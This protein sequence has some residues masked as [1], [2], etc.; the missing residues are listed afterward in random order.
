MQK[1]TPTNHLAGYMRIAIKDFG[2]I[3]AGEIT[4]KPL[5]ILVGPNGCGKTHVSTL[6][7]SVVESER[8]RID[9]TL[10]KRLF[11]KSKNWH[12]DDISPK[13][14]LEKES[15]RIY[16]KHKLNAADID[17]DISK[18]VGDFWVKSFNDTLQRNIL[19]T[20]DNKIRVNKDEF[21]LDIESKISY[22]KFKYVRREISLEVIK[23]NYTNLKIQFKKYNNSEE[24][25]SDDKVYRGDSTVHVNIPTICDVN[26]IY[27]SLK[28]AVEFT[29]IPDLKRSVFFPAERSGLSHFI[30]S[31]SPAI[32]AARKKH[33]PKNKEWP[34]IFLSWMS[35]I[36]NNKSEF[37]TITEK[38]EQSMLNGKIAAKA[39]DISGINI[40]YE[41]NKH[42]WPFQIT[43]TASY[44]KDLAYFFVYVKYVAKKHDVIILE[45]PEINLHPS[46]QILLARLIV[47]LVN[48][49]LCIVVSTHSPYFL[50]QLSHCVVGGTIQDKQSKAVLPRD[51]C[52]KYND[53]SVYRFAPD[54]DNDNGYAIQ[55][56]E[57][58]QDGI[59]QTEFTAVDDTL[60]NELTKLRQAE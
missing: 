25:E 12:L 35:S 27:N 41:Q 20:F 47:N 40:Q 50:E 55:N 22:G 53:V 6:I 39:K 48:A 37:T 19:S 14:I 44:I 7:H 60:Y 45:E 57:V 18:Y 1:T 51:E 24:M 34:W 23:T 58:G 36:N 15:Q 49:G 11:Q 8:N 38:F 3:S 43:E 52:I 33:L 46:N 13:E 42:K 26:T 16:K 9:W 54:N 28:S 59:A 29:A 10:E 21:E 17:S 5:T 2:P 56:V 30:K 4:L 31:S 32:I